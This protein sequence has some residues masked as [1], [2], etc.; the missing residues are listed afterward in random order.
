M[1]KNCFKTFP[2]YNIYF[3]LRSF[4]YMIFFSKLPTL[5]VVVKK[6]YHLKILL[7]NIFWIFNRFLIDGKQSKKIPV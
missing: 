7:I 1:I 6:N 5:I 2:L 3:P 4:E